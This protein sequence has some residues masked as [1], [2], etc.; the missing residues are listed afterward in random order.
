MYYCICTVVLCSKLLIHMKQF[1]NNHFTSFV[2]GSLTLSV[3]SGWMCLWYIQ[4]RPRAAHLSQPVAA[5]VLG[6]DSS[7]RIKSREELRLRAMVENALQSTWKENLNNAFHAQERFMLPGRRR[8]RHDGAD[9]PKF[10]QK[11]DQRCDELM[12][13]QLVDNK[14]QTRM[15]EMTTEDDMANRGETSHDTTQFWK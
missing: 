11:I 8:R 13:Q 15:E 14:K 2:I 12:K 7:R 4:G 1:I 6:D 9:D 3:A 10:I 5:S